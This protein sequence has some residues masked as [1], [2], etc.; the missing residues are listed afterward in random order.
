[1]DS[2]CFSREKRPEYKKAPIFSSRLGLVAWASFNLCQ[3]ILT[4]YELTGRVAK[5]KSQKSQTEI[6][7]GITGVWQCSRS[8]P[9][10]L[11]PSAG[12]NSWT[13]GCKIYISSIGLQFG[14]VIGRA[15]LSRHA[16]D[17]SRFSQKSPLS[18]HIFWGGLDLL[19]LR[20]YQEL[21]YRTLLA[22]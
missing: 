17:K 22:D 10:Y 2:P 1:M 13:H 9:P 14:T 8:L 3:P 11:I 15:Q 7:Y 21:R 20:L 6:P 5:H 12:S 16:L 18:R 19:G 4:L